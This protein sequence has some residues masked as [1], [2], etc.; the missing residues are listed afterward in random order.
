MNQKITVDSLRREVFVGKNR[1]NLAP[2]EFEILTLLLKNYHRAMGRN[3][4]ADIVWGSPKIS[5]RT[6]DQHI[7]RMR[8]KI[9]VAFLE[10]V[11]TYGYRIITKSF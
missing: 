8:R 1:I 5:S 3:E 2:K 11:P 7:C 9:G 4:I 10:T 6:I